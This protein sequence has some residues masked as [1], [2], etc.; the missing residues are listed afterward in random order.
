VSN[1]KNVAAVYQGTLK[2]GAVL[3]DVFDAIAVSLTSK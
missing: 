1:K 2:T 3:D